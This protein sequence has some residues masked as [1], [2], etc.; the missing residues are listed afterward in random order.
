MACFLPRQDNQEWTPL[1]DG[2]HHDGMRSLEL[3]EKR[4]SIEEWNE[5]QKQQIEHRPVQEGGDIIHIHQGNPEEADQKL[6]QTWIHSDDEK[7]E[8][9]SEKGNGNG[10]GFMGCWSGGREDVSP[11]I[12]CGWTDQGLPAEDLS[13][14]NQGKV[15]QSFT[16]QDVSTLIEDDNDSKDSQDQGFFAAICCSFCS[17]CLVK[18]LA[19]TLIIAAIFSI[20][21]IIGKHMNK[22]TNT[23]AVNGLAN[24]DEFSPTFDV[25]LPPSPSPAT[26]AEP[27]SQTTDT[28]SQTIDT[29]TQHSPTAAPSQ[30]SASRSNIT[31]GVY[32]Y[33][34]HGDNFHNGGGY[35]R[36]QLD[37]P[38]LPELGEYDDTKDETIQQHL[39]WSRQANI[40]L[41]VASWW[42]ANRL[43]DDTIKN[44][45]L[46]H[47]DLG[48][49]KIALHYETSGRIRADEGYSTDRV[50][51]D[52]EYMCAT[53]FDHP[54]Y[55]RIDGRPVLVMYI[56]R[57]YWLLGILEEIILLMRTAADGC[58][59]SIYLVGDQVFQQPPAASEVYMPFFYLDAVTNYD[60]YGSM[61]SPTYYAG[62]DVVDAYYQE[63]QIWRTRALAQ[64]CSF[65][66]AVSPGFNDRGVRLGVDHPALARRLTTSS[67][68]G[69][70][71]E[72]AL[73]Q[74]RSLVDPSVNNL[75][76]V[77]SFN[78]WH[79]DSQ[80]EPV[81][82]AVGTTLPDSLTNGVEYEG[83]GEVFLNILREGTIDLIDADT[84]DNVLNNNGG[85]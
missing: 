3:K 56:S 82:V 46:Q 39:S 80:I 23:T 15:N 35:L 71:F 64:Q 68:P 42:G 66:P 52:I 11:E 41:W 79:E 54:N 33:P 30:N 48:D 7:S 83:Y 13:N 36:N 20:G 57:K 34:W 32:Y 76:L 77:N 44:V 8:Q 12:A 19:I 29:P 43:E 40:N 4:R 78:E 31:V 18:G 45:I 59:H 10:L 74:A 6:D 69:S 27:I 22:A 28:I 58:G 49:M 1:E 72:Y 81:A 61:R 47:D 2:D 9:E 67:A 21:L 38:Q 14:A 84:T 63:Q 25:T 65:I 60:V 51:G 75:L 37:P 50:R 24:Q 55:Y 16:T 62:A 53:Y 5:G 73:K 85:T 17:P 70:L 26:G